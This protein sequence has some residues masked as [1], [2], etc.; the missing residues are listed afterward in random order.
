MH[1]GIVGLGV[2][3]IAF[4]NAMIH[5]KDD[6]EILFLNPMSSPIIELLALSMICLFVTPAR[7]LCL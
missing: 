1:I 7:R 2:S 3:G 5:K 6:V 4:I